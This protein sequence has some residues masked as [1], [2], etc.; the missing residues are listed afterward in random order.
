MKKYVALTVLGLLMFLP[1]VA[2]ADSCG[3]GLVATS[4]TSGTGSL[5]EV[6]L[7]MSGNT[8]SIDSVFQDGID[9]SGTVKIFTIAWN[10][11]ADLISETDPDNN[12]TNDAQVHDDGWQSATASASG[13][14]VQDPQGLPITFTFG[15]GDTPTEFTIHV[16]S[17]ADGCSAW[18]STLWEESGPN[19]RGNNCTPIP[20]P[21]TLT[22]LGTGLLGLAGVVR[23]RLGKKS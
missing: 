16:G 3:G 10:T 21:A 18:P 12:W 20:E 15:N 22:L 4:Y 11:D 9:V 8:L 23:K 6:C 13:T 14:P 5:I 2:R 7:S 17:F 19:N 1:S